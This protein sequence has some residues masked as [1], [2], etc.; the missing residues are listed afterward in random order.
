LA[1]AATA[2]AD[3]FSLGGGQISLQFVPV[4]NLGNGGELSGSSAGGYGTDRICGAVSYSYSI[5][6]FEV[7][8]GQYTSFLNAVA[9]TDTYG[10]YNQSMDRTTDSYGCNIIRSG[11]SGS[12]SYSIASDWAN[13]PVNFVS[14][15]DAARFAN[16][17]TNGQKTGA[18]DST[19]T[20]DGSYALNGAN[21]DALLMAVTRRADARFVIPTEDEWYKAAYHKNDGVTDH[22]WDFAAGISAVPSH[23]LTSPD[24]GNN[25]NFYDSDFGATIGSPYYRTTVGAFDRSDSP[26]GTFDQGGN[27]SEWTEAI[28]GTS[29]RQKR[30]GS[31]L[32][33]YS[34]MDAA[35]RGYKTTPTYE[36]STNGFRLVELPEPATLSLMALG[37]LVALRRSRRR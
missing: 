1:L 15:G 33:T 2:Q 27:V 31:F 30:G 4:G 36:E 22:Y 37:G 21:T 13:R 23:I 9:K 6:T 3:V 5:G 16:W 8:A 29:F 32:D 11:A 24:P 12:Y 28:L 34:P 18:Q 17:V 19:T 26:Y 25:A 10:L 14:W 7:T 20:E 35:D